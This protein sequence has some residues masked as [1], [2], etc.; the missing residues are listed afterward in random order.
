MASVKGDTVEHQN[1][2]HFHFFCFLIELFPS[3]SDQ[4]Y[5]DCN[6]NWNNFERHWLQMEQ[7]RVESLRT[8]MVQIPTP[9][10]CFDY[11]SNFHSFELVFLVGRY[12]RKQRIWQSLSKTRTSLLMISGF[13]ALDVDGI[14][15][16]LKLIWTE[17][18]NACL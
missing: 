17:S 12:Q 7:N 9:L 11:N 2:H 6:L 15:T 1:N 18:F 8:Q 13:L 5:F 3:S 14:T 4:N 10:H 16:I